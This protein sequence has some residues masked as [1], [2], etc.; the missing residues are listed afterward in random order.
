MRNPPRAWLLFASLAGSL[1]LFGAC[2]RPAE[3]N[4]TS[5]KSA[6]RLGVVEFPTSGSSAAQPHFLRGVAALHSFW[7]DEALEAF[8]AA[9]Q[10]DPK[11]AMAWWGTAMAWKRP[12]M[13]GSD[14]AAGR[15]A[16]A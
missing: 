12:F 15:Q 9:R 14:V 1:V 13:P 11:F 16:L 2:S 3:V 8:A 7:Y 6:L 5:A 4:G 10:A